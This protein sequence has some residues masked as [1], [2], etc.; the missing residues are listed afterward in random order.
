MV[1]NYRYEQ[2]VEDTIM[3]PTK[4]SLEPL[5]LQKPI[6]EEEGPRELLFL[7]LRSRRS[8]MLSIW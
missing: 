7:A 4:I 5:E 2:R 8:M 6:V 1:L 3:L